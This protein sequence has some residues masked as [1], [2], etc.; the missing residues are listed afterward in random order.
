MT[1]HG[2]GRVVPFTDA[3]V[4]TLLHAAAMAPSVHNTQPWQFAVGSRRIDLYADPRRQLRRADPTGRSLLISCGAALLNLRVA[5]EHLGYRPR[6]RRQPDRDTPT[7][8]ATVSFDHWHHTPGALGELF[9]AIERRRT[10]RWPFQERAIASSTLARLALEAE[11][12]NAL[13]RVYSDPDEVH[14]LVR[15]IHDADFRLH[16]DLAVTGERAAWIGYGDRRDGMPT[17]VLGPRPDSMHTPFRDL[18]AG[19]DPE[20]ES[21][22]FER[23][24]TVA[25]LSTR[26]DGPA[27]WVRAGEALERVLLAATLEDVS[28]SF[29]NQPLDYEELRWLVRSPVTGVGHPQMLMRLGYGRPVPPSPRRPVEEMLRPG[30]R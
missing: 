1:T 10:N 17:E 4:Q 2:A 24:P 8:V 11:A 30:P 6:V 25:V 21:A 14:R 28:A 3:D 26:H 15:L 22:R 16:T 7:L 23:T 19:P 5:A 29:M 27:D 20:R 18:G 12:E 9:P 13:L